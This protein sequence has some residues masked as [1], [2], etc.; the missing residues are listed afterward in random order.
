MRVVNIDSPR[1]SPALGQ[2]SPYQTSYS[3]P[4]EVAFRLIDENG[5]HVV[6]AGKKFPYV[7]TNVVGADGSPIQSGPINGTILSKEGSL[8]RIPL[9]IPRNVGDFSAG[10]Q[11]VNGVLSLYGMNGDVQYP[12]FENRKI[13]F[14]VPPA[15]PLPL[16]LQPIYEKHD[17]DT[18]AAETAAQDEIMAEKYASM[19]AT[20]EEAKVAADK[21]QVAAVDAAEKQQA[22]E[23]AVQAAI[24]PNPRNDDMMWAV[25]G[26]ASVSLFTYLAFVK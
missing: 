14:T 9:S 3:S 23:V 17:A 7:I 6:N 16:D 5:F 26:I 21:A 22:A 10:D 8:L 12:I 18:Y 13:M 19:V 24:N 1:R 15:S 4:R 11:P 20:E 25:A 2:Y